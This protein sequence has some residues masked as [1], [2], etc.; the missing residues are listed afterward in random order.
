MSGSA[1][2]CPACRAVPASREELRLTSVRSLYE[3][4]HEGY[5]L[6]ACPDCGQ[7]FLEQFQEI[8][9]RPDGEDLIWLRWMPITTEELAEVERLF[10]A[11]TED[12]TNTHHLAKLMHRRGRLV[13]DP[14]GRFVWSD[15][16]WDAGNLYPPG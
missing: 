7:T 13:R 6:F 10:P 16:A 15:R 11:E 3:G 2:G 1:L 8:T 4:P 14:E 5:A 9:W 12:D